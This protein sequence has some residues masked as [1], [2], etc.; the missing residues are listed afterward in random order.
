MLYNINKSCHIGSLTLIN[1]VIKY[2]L[3]VWGQYHF[4]N[5]SKKSLILSNAA[6]FIK[7]T[8]MHIR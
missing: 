3:E 7:N 6:L 5:F 1:I 8:F 4:F 2:C